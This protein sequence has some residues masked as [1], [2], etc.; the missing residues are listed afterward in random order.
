MPATTHSLP[1]PV[2]PT[3]ARVDPNE[4]CSSLIL[5][6][7]SLRITPICSVVTAACKVKTR[8]VRCNKFPS[9]V[10][11][12]ASRDVST[13]GCQTPPGESYEPSLIADDD[14]ALGIEHYDL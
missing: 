3:T 1:R 13:S 7:G 11:Q 2:R 14:P 10:R 6:S 8:Q 4:S 9:C 5:L 12:I